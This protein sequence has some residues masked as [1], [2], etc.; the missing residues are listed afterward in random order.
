MSSLRPGAYAGQERHG[1]VAAAAAMVGASTRGPRAAG[2]GAVVVGA[3]V[4]LGWA[5]DLPRLKSVLPGLVEMKVNTAIGFGLAGASL[6][7]RGGARARQRAGLAC[8]SVVSLIGLLTAVEYL[9]GWDLGIDQAIVREAAGTVA[10]SSPGRMA[11]TTAA[12]FLLCGLA[13]LWLDSGRA[14]WRHLAE[15]VVVPVALNSLLVAA[16]Y[17]Y[18]IHSLVGIAPNMAMAVHTSLGFAALAAGVLLARSDGAFLRLVTAD[19]AGGAAARRFL[20]V[21]VFPIAVGW[22][23][24]AGMRAGLYDE[25]L[26]AAL[27]GIVNVA[28]LSGFAWIHARALHRIDLARSQAQRELEKANAELESRIAHRTAELAGAN[29][30]LVREQGRLRASEAALRDRE[31][32][33]ATTLNSIGDGVIATDTENRVVR[34]NPVAER[35][36]GWKLQEARARSLTEVFVVIDEETGQ[37]IVNP[38]DR[39]LSEGVVVGLAN[40]AALV[41][42]DG[43]RCPVA[44][45]AAPIRDAAGEVKGVVLVF[46]DVTAEK[47]A[48]QALSRAHSQLELS[49]RMASLGTLAAGVGHEIN[50]P[51]ASIIANLE[52]TGSMLHEVSGLLPAGRRQEMTEMVDEMRDGADR[53][54]LIVRDLRNFCRVDDKQLGPVDLRRVVEW[55]ITMVWNEIRHR[56]RL[57]KDF[58]GAPAAQG[59][60]PRLGQVVVNLLINA[61]QAIREGNAEDNEIRIV[62]RTDERGWSVLEVR[63]TGCGIAPE[64][65]RRIFDPFFTTKDVGSGTGLGLFVCHGIV[66]D[67]G[68]EL[69]LESEPGRGACFR[70]A[71]PPA[72]IGPSQAR[73]G[74]TTMET[75]PDRRRGRVLI[76]D[77][78]PLVVAALRRCLAPE[79]DVFTSIRAADVLARIEKGERFDVIVCDLMM[80][81]MTGM[82]LHSRLLQT[83]PS[84]AARMVFLTGGAFTPEAGEFLDR[85][86]NVRVEK[87]FD[88]QALRALVRDRLAA[89]GSGALEKRPAPVGV[90]DRLACCSS[91]I[92]TTDG[93]SDLAWAPGN[94]ERA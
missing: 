58:G 57:V 14:R 7:L 28:T 78:E 43:T 36:T 17:A 33:L 38:A 15:F 40:H 70:V 52:S 18:G 80:P 21:A 37:P 41:A 82:D 12:C 56:A 39:A 94:R 90:S 75:S 16:G 22:L 65:Q 30:D 64:N 69:S 42:R 24:R 29:E 67:L 81:E 72:P 50:N 8:A 26:C 9:V 34:M 62:T 49:A 87:P 55:S 10:T 31:E 44:D 74:G 45:S 88:P 19:T 23:G 71:L 53:I 48:Q 86:A 5:F 4:L 13:L 6:L 92:T 25:G 77:D 84:D 2:A 91:G 20:P 79:H 46:R 47:E 66:T 93:A 76:I 89:T 54:R 32:H 61:A 83:R 73:R 35:I 27:V 59:N 60:E 63:D 3:I 68:G 1:H 85:V 51:L 11:P